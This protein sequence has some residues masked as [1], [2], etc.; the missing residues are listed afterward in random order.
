MALPQTGAVDVTHASGDGDGSVPV[1]DGLG[2]INDQV[3]DDLPQLRRVAVDVG[4]LRGQVGGEGH[5]LARRKLQQ[6]GRFVDQ[7]VEVDRL[8]DKAAFAGVIEHLFAQLGGASRGSD[9]AIDV[10]T[11]SGITG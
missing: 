10:R 2:G 9:D 1:A 3:H 5:V 4:K 6:R 8:D 11:D 7:A